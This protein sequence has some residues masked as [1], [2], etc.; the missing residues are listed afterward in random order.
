[1]T[2]NSHDVVVDWLPQE[3]EVSWKN[4]L[5]NVLEIFGLPGE[6]FTCHPTDLHMVVK[7]K[8]AKDATMCRLLLSEKVT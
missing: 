6:R 7:F 1:M 5:A 2:H 3:N 8:H 4:P